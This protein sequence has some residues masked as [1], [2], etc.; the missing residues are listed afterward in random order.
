MPC[1]SRLLGLLHRRARSSCRWEGRKMVLLLSRC[2]A[3]TSTGGGQ[4][5]RDIHSSTS[6][7]LFLTPSYLPPRSTTQLCS[8][9][10]RSDADAMEDA[11]PPLLRSVPPT[12]WR[13]PLHPCSTLKLAQA[14]GRRRH[15][16]RRSTPAPIRAPNAMEDAPPPLLQ[17]KGTPPLLHLSFGQN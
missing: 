3:V 8:S 6:H 9:L 7:P 2:T 1:P 13:T 17:P 16:G 4:A 12:P 15:G 10:G 5:K 11:A 14:P